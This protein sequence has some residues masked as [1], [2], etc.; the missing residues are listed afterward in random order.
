M[1]RHAMCL[2]TEKNIA[3]ICATDVLLPFVYFLQ[4][5]F[6]APTGSIERNDK[7]TP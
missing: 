1:S 3:G 2:L 7:D 5:D 6:H 4:I